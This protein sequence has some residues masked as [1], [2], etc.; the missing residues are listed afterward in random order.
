M[1]L[2]RGRGDRKTQSLLIGSQ[3]IGQ[4]A[5]LGIHGG[6]RAHGLHT[7]PRITGLHALFARALQ[8]LQGPLTVAERVV[9]DA[10]AVERLAFVASPLPLLRE[11]ERQVEQS[12]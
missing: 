9:V 11:G 8:E 6:E 2:D 3:G 10:D 1:S 12:Q 7:A 4:S 5:L